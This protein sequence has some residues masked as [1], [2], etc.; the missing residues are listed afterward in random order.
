MDRISDLTGQSLEWLQPKT[1]E[2][3]FELQAGPAQLATL[4]FHSAWGTLA[5]AETADG[6]WAFRRVGFLTRR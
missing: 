5:T 3:H 2:R 6:T 1:L 4:T